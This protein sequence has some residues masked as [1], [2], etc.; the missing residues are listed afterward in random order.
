MSF[1]EIRYGLFF[2][3]GGS[4]T[5]TSL[6]SFREAKEKKEAETALFWKR[7]KWRYLGGRVH[8]AWFH[9]FP[10]IHCICP[11]WRGDQY[12]RNVYANFWRI[13]VERHHWPDCPGPSEDE[14]LEIER[15]MEREREKEREQERASEKK[16]A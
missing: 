2:N 13:K 11:I 9:E 7:M 10:C 6:A 1:F 3:L 12:V 5:V 16:S 15:Q 14:V 4:M 8:H